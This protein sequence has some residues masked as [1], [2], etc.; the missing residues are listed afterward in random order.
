MAT[1]RSE[2][3]VATAATGPGS[4]SAMA[5]KVVRAAV[6]AMGVAVAVETTRLRDRKGRAAA[7]AAAA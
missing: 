6:P 2:A 5:A 4:T 7:M 3:V 1:S